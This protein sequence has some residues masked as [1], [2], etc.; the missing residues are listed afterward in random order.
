MTEKPR[1][2]YDSAE[3]FIVDMRRPPTDPDSP[4][5]GT[6][7][8][9]SEVVDLLNNLD[10]YKREVAEVAEVMYQFTMKR[11]TQQAV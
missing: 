5:L 3:G 1:Y 8:L 10:D 6:E 11:L 7:L 4:E 9:M 2:A